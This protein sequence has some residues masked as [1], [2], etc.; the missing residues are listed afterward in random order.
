MKYF[1]LSDGW[2]VGRVWE[3]GGLWNE[4]AWRR[5][6]QIDRLNICIWE[7]GEKLWLYRVEDEILMVEVKPTENVESSSIGQVVLKRLITADQAI[8]LIGS[9]VEF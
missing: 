7:N 6:P 5:K 4:T 2:S 9:N 8:D 1:F 3:L